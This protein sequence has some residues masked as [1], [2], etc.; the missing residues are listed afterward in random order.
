MG[1]C[2]VTVRTL[3]ASAGAAQSSER[4]RSEFERLKWQ[5][6]QVFFKNAAPAAEHQNKT[7]VFKDLWILKTLQPSNM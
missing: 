4:H 6:C 7:I 1:V 3:S 2:L 5:A